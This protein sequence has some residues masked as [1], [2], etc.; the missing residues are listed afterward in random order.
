MFARVLR[1]ISLAFVATLVIASPVSQKRTT[2]ISSTALVP[3][4]LNGWGGFSVLNGFD[5]F[6][7][8]DNFSGLN[9]AEALL[10]QQLV[11]G[12]GTGTSLSV[13]VVQQQLAV[14]A[15]LAQQ[16]ILTQLCEVEVQMLAFQQFLGGLSGF[17]NDL[18]RI[19]GSQP[20]FDAVIAALGSSLFLPG[21]GFNT[22]LNFS[23]LNIGQNSQLVTSNWSNQSSFSSVSNALAQ[24]QIA[25]LSSNS[26]SQLSTNLNSVNNVDSNFNNNNNVNTGN[27][28]GSV[29]AANGSSD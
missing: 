17:S 28:L 26:N 18:L 2:L 10:E 16:A 21:G 9:N 12:A 22:N 14:L 24:A 11:C 8:V 25:A 7:G 13:D 1:L 19:D 6:F 5:N 29:A 20:S 23:G 27:A 15:Q 3:V 4:S